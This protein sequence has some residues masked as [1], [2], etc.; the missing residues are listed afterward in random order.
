MMLRGDKVFRQREGGFT[1]IEALIALVVL[2][3]GLLAIA[4]LQGKALQYSHSSYQRSVAVSQANDAVER[5]WANICLLPDDLDDIVSD[6]RDVHS[7]PDNSPGMDWNASDS[8]IVVD[9]T[10][11]PPIYTIT[12]SWNDA[13]LDGVE[14]FVY[15]AIVPGLACSS[16]T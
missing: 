2:S 7:D 4:A 9:D 11:D 10:V 16:G 5:L 1:L 3:I 15:T 12:V 14:T 6:W 8:D 13:R